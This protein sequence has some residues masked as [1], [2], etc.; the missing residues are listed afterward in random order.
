MTKVW[1]AKEAV[2]KVDLNS[3]I[4]ITTAGALDTFF[5]G[6]VTGK[7][8]TGVMKDIT[9]TEPSIDVEK[10]DL[11]GNTSS[12]QNAELEEKPASM[13]EVS[14]TAILPGDEVSES[15]FYPTVDGPSGF[16]RYQPG[17]SSITKVALLLNL[18]DSTDEVSYAG[19]NMVVSARESKVT[20]PD[21]HFEV[22]WTLKCLPK[23]WFGPEFK[24]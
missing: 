5:T 4:T 1:H 16:T 12:F 15:V 13:V 2:I 8:I 11:M 20:G 22:T 19:V 18:D 3:A 10:I 14:G 6:T 24:D 23:D 9:I 21:G 17:Q 7:T